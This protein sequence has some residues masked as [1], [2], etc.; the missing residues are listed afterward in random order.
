MY[1]CSLKDIQKLR[2]SSHTLDI[3]IEVKKSK[4]KKFIHEIFLHG[5]V[6]SL[7]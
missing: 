6:V 3:P 1:D 7:E 5:N 2:V 4:P